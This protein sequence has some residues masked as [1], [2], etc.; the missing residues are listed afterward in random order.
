VKQSGLFSDSFNN[1]NGLL[2]S[3]SIEGEIMSKQFMGVAVMCFL[4]ALLI[5][6]PTHA[7][8]PGMAERVVIPFD[9]IVRGKT[10]PAGT[11]TVRRINDSSEALVMENFRLRSHVTFETEPFESRSAP[12]RSELVFHRYGD[13]Y[14][15]RQIRTAG[16]AEAVELATS[17]AER[18]LQRESAKNNMTGPETV[19][20]ALY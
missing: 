4:V 9:F 19:A 12:E 5:A 16:E 3:A 1:W 17:R 2:R 15:L 8:N 6:S 10:L 20:L 18:E 11:Y 14:F 7:Q 13:T